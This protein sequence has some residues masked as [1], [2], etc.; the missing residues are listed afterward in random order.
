MNTIVNEKADPKGL[1]TIGGVAAL[2]CALM[3]ILTLVI[4]IP[5]NL[6]SP[7]PTTVLEWFKVFEESPITGLFFLGLADII[8]MILWGPMA[9]ALYFALRKSNRTWTMIATPF[10]FVG[11]AVY[12]AT[13]TAFSMLSLSQEYASAASEAE[14][15]ILV[16]AGQAMIAMTRGS[17]VLYTGMPLVWIA[18][19]IF[20]VVMLRNESFSRANAWVGITGFGLLVVG[21]I[22]GG[23]YTSAG[24]YTA[25]QG[26]L[27]AI[28]YIGGGLLS[29]TWYFLVGLR[30]LKLSRSEASSAFQEHP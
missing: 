16:T 27:V 13:N 20:S 22:G 15:V 11:M 23:H 6:A 26:A 3:Y 30:L 7:P 8:I 10:V 1:F 18:G 9:L 28:Q 5:A 4:Y 2:L 21:I 12:L 17:G 29:L 14:K 25:L 24:E 19:V